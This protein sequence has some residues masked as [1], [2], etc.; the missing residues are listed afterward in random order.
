MTSLK[1]KYL[2]YCYLQDTYR[3]HI[4][5][6]PLG[7]VG[8]RKADLSTSVENEWLC[9]KLLA[10]YG[11]PVAECE[12]LTFG[13]RKVLS[14]TRFDRKPHP[15]G[16][17]L[18]RLP[19]EDFCQV[20]GLS[21]LQKYEADGGPG[22]VEI[23]GV[24]RYSV[25][26]AEDLH[27][28]MA[29]QLLFWLLAAPDGHAKNF[30][31]RLLAGG[32]YR[33]TPLYDVMSIVVGHGA[34]Q[35]SWHKAKLAMAVVGKNRH[36]GFREIQRRHFN[37]MAPRCFLGADAEPVI[38]HILDQ[39]PVVIDRVSAAIPPGFPQKVADTILDGLRMSVQRLAAMPAKARE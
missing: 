32:R 23:A 11:L 37:A 3:I 36:Y 38:R 34:S 15:S 21:S 31:I 20:F 9:L 16:K 10:A 27:T 39:T 18:L 1:Q 5:K 17:W 25:A 6:L 28:L 2:C 4:F 19:Q 22:L 14:V 35:F 29:A 24:L 13:R 8:N 33:M 26:Q 30:S 7:L 12:M